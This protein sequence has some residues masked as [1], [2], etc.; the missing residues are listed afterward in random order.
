MDVARLI[1][2]LGFLVSGAVVIGVSV[3]LIRGW[4]RPN[5]WYGFRVRRTLEDPRVW[6]PANRYAAWWMAGSAVVWMVVAAGLYAVPGL[7]LVGYALTCGGVVA[8]GLGVGLVRSFR[9][10][11]TLGS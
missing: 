4:V 11:R 8:A 6:Y 2:L 10:L 3:P 5:S 7:G 9:Y 1:V